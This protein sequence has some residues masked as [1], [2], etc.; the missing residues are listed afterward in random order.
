[1]CS[2]SPLLACFFAVSAVSWAAPSVQIFTDPPSPQPVGTVIGITAIGKDEGEPEK[3][4]SLLRYRLSAADE[5][6]TFH[7]IRDFSRQAEFTW[8]PELYDYEAR[9]KVTVL[10]TKT[11][12]TGEA[13]LPF[14]ISPRVAGQTPVV[15]HTAHPLIALFSFPPCRD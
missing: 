8:T 4:A 15:A 12:Q 3:Y 11:K 6:G 9:V 14:R 1:M 13:E 7:I 2:K 10:N 5:G